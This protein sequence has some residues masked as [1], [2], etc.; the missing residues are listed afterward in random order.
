M[1]MKNK[2]LDERLRRMQE[3]LCDPPKMPEL[4]NGFFKK[5]EALELLEAALE[6]QLYEIEYSL[7]TVKALKAEIQEK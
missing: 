2:K 5:L 1:E 4:S 6:L 7:E 3:Y